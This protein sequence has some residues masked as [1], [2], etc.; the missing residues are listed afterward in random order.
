MSILNTWPA[1]R[2]VS[3]TATPLAVTPPAGA[4]EKVTIGATLYPEPLTFLVTL[5]TELLFVIN[6]LLPSERVEPPIKGSVPMPERVVA[7]VVLETNGVMVETRTGNA[8]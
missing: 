1:F 8:C 3:N 7:V 6:T 5:D 4:G 2:P